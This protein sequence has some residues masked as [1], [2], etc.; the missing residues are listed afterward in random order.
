VAGAVLLAA[1]PVL[2]DRRDKDE[3]D[4][5]VDSDDDDDDDDDESVFNELASCVLR[6]LS[7]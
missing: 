1:A 6:L 2:L 3:L 5:D 7:E 4:E